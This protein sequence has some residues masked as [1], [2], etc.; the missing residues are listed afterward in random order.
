LDPIAPQPERVDRAAELIRQGQ[1][2]AIP[3]DTLYG[4]AA[5]PFQIAAVER[6]FAIKRRPPSE[7]VLLLVDSIRMAESLAKGPPASFRALAERYWPGR[8]T[9]VVEASPRIPALVTA[10][11]GWVG[12]RFPAAAIPQAIIEAFRGPITG[13]SANRSGD[14]ACRSA[15]EAVSA[16]GSDLPL[17]LDG[18]PSPLAVPSTV[19]RIAGD[20]WELIRE[21][22]IPQADLE[23]FFRRLG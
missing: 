7:P 2:V 21:G 6:V 18:G 9:M 23:S 8:L 14:P 19:V 22:A 3:T 5:D 11:T 16:L 13:T 4:L 15:A 20:E 17:I 10:N 1:I 12:L